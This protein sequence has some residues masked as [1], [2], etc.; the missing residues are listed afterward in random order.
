MAENT[1]INNIKPWDERSLNHLIEN[2]IKRNWELMALSDLG[3]ISF[4]FSEVAENVE[5]LHILFEAAG[6]KPGDKVAICGKNSAVWAL[7]FIACLTSGTVAVPILHEFK[8]DNIHTLVNHSEA[9]I[10]FV[11]AAIWKKL[12]A[13]KLPNLVGA[14]FLSEKGAPLPLEETHSRQR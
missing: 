5:K 11:D 9:K 1:K 12:D 10:L 3:G 4:K 7:V 6:V 2:A 8:P 14:F 13:E